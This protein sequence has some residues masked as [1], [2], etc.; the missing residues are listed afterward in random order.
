MSKMNLNL[1]LLLT[2]MNY[3]KLWAKLKKNQLDW[4]I[5]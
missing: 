4:L 2:N 5:I 1:Y 3:T